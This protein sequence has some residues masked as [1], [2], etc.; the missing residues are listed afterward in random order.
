M[1]YIG[2]IDREKLKK[3]KYKIVTDRVVLTEERI[4]HIKKHHPGDYEMYEKYIT[5][6]LTNPDFILEDSKNLDTVLYLKT[7]QKLEKNIQIVVKLNTN[8]YEKYKSNSILTMWKVKDSTYRQLVRNKVI[9][10]KKAG[11]E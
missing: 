3:Y 6:I 9:L 8:K 2:K 10:W 11:Q 7:I 1:Q 4:K 5:S